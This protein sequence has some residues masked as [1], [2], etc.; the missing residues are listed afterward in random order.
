MES[1]SKQHK[2]PDIGWRFGKMG[3]DRHQWKCN[4]CGLENK[5]GGVIRLKQHLVG[6][7]SDVKKCPKIPAEVRVMTREHMQKEKETKI[8]S[9]ARREACDRRTSQSYI[10]I[11]LDNDDDDYGDPDDLEAAHLQEAIRASRQ[12][13]WQQEEV[14]RHRAQF[15]RSQF[16]K[17]GG[18]SAAVRSRSY[19]Q[20]CGIERS[21]STRMESVRKCVLNPIV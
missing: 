8:A 18:S 21:Q 7:F 1:D 3:K 19:L 5:G 17:G 20:S 9:R 11:D 14:L 4:F 2:D 6:G 16:E 15:G 12:D 10:H 13:Q